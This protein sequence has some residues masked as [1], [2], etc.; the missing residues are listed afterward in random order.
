[1]VADNKIKKLEKSI[2]SENYEM[3]IETVDNLQEVPVDIQMRLILNHYDDFL[4]YL[5]YEDKLSPETYA[6]SAATGEKVQQLIKGK[7]LKDR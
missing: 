6:L 3:F 4:E 5:I 2:T 1:M 7:K